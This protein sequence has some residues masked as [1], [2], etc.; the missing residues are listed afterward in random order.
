MDG[1][2][3]SEVTFQE[4]TEELVHKISQPT[5]DI[6]LDRNRELRKNA[7]AI[8]DLGAQTGEGTWGRQL[9]SIPFI[10]YD[11]ALRDG[12]DLNSKDA[13]FAGREMQRYLQTPEGKT[14]LVQGD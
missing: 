8:Q 6:I 10:M 14:C 9:A 12:Y 3:K 2:Y 4:H 5:Q 7:G 1:V 13:D 11:K